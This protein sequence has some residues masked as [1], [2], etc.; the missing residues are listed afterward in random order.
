MPNMLTVTLHHA[1]RASRK[2][3]AEP[4]PSE[5]IYYVIRTPER[6]ELMPY[7][8]GNS[9][10]GQ[11]E[12]NHCEFW[13]AE[14]APYLAYLWTSHVR[15]TARQLA[16]ERLQEKLEDHCY[17]FPR[18]RI[19]KGKGNHHRIWNGNNL[20]KVM[21]SKAQIEGAFMIQGVCEWEFD[22]HEQCIAEETCEVQEILPIAEKWPTVGPMV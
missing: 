21:P 22:F 12:S 9:F 7:L 11:P 5:G 2:L 16:Q 17:G 20:T 19:T 3:A 8:F 18:G 14:V 15:A 6:W 4:V 13:K 1:R 10:G